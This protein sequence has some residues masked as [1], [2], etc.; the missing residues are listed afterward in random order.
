MRREVERGSP[1]G[2]FF[3]A[4]SSR[5][6]AQPVLGGVPGYPAADAWDSGVCLVAG[7]GPAH[8][9]ILSSEAVLSS[10]KVV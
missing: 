5:R 7:C 9:G 6:W 8:S 10:R 2:P 4:A 3:K 1:C